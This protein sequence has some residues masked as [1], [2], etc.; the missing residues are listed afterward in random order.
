VAVSARI[1]A[2]ALM[3]CTLACSRP[4]LNLGEG[5]QINSDCA[6]PLACVFGTCRRQCFSSRDCGAGLA[7]NVSSETLGGGCQLPEEAVCTLTS[8]CMTP[9][10]PAWVCQ[11]GTCTTPCSDARDCAPGAVC[12]TDATEPLGCHDTAVQPCLYNSDCDAPM[13][14]DGDQRC[15]LECI[16][17]RDCPNPRLCVGNLCELPDAGSGAD[18]GT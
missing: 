1:A 7:C 18:G 9:G 14:C 6:D 13:I 10:H 4:S 8:E 3:A 17:D 5:C 12:I 2:I 11:Y 15:R 16:V